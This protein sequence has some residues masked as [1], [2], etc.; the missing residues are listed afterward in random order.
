MLLTLFAVFAIAAGAQMER[1]TKSD[2]LEEI[3]L[4]GT[5]D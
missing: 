3:I 4:V 1:G 2:S 5:D